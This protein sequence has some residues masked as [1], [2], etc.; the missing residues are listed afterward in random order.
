MAER[1]DAVT[2]K[3]NPLTLTGTPVQVGDKA[4]FFSAVNNALE[5]VTLDDFKGGVL[6][7]ASVP[8]LDTSVCSMETKRFN[9]EAATLSPDTMLVTISMDLPFAQKRWVEEHDATRVTTI[10]YHKEASFGTEYGLLIK[11]LR[12]LARCVIVIDRDGKVAYSQLVPEVTDEPDYDAA[13]EAARKL[14]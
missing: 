11:E 13:L 8:S 4:P 9:D 3:G 2:M 14:S 5:P 7:L 12:L 6:I 1:K 10:S